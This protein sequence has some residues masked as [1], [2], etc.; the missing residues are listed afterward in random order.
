[1]IIGNDII[2]NLNTQSWLSMKSNHK[3]NMISQV[4]LKGML[5]EK[6]QSIVKNIYRVLLSRGM[7]GCF[8]YFM[9]KNT[10]N[11]VKTRIKKNQSN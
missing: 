2:Y 4:K 1:M 7:K 8:V 5:D 11:F 10:E 6:Y 9:D 3:G